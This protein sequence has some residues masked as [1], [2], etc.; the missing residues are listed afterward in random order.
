MKIKDDKFIVKIVCALI[1]IVLWVLA[2]MQVNPPWDYE[3]SNIKVNVKNIAKLEDGN[4]VLMEDV[5]NFI[6][7]VKLSGL[8]NNLLK[9]KSSDI[10]A[11]IDLNKIV[12]KDK[13]GE[14]R[15]PVEITSLDNFE[16]LSFS[17]M[18][19]TCT[20]EKEISKAIDVTVK[21]T[22]VVNDNYYVGRG[23]SKPASIIIRGAESRVESVSEALA[24]VNVNGLEK[25]ITKSI[26]LML[27][28]ANNEDVNGVVMDKS[29]VSI[30]QPIYE[31][32]T[33]SVKPDFIGEPKEGYKLMD[34]ISE[35]TTV[36]IAGRRNILD[37]ISNIITEPLD[38]R[39]QIV[40]VVNDKSLILEDGILVVDNIDK[41]K[42]VAKID[43]IITKE[44]KFNYEDI[45]F[46][47]LDGKYIAKIIDE[48][49]LETE[50]SQVEGSTGIS[51]NNNDNNSSDDDKNSN[52]DDDDK[53]DYDFKVIIKDGISKIRDLDK[54]DIKLYIDCKD[55]TEGVNV[56][57]V[58]LNVNEQFEETSV[59]PDKISVKVELK[60]ENNDKDESDE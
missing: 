4:Y 40:N 23:I 13:S 53:K 60:P 17:P 51:Q 50:D 38:I 42:V 25:D 47:N 33:V 16:V 18:Y 3:F 44:F 52:N 35:R 15:I 6:V 9:I 56:I 32:K 34:V 46:E 10:V 30:T 14:H 58:M 5:N 29:V 21:H 57:I 8:K 45:E 49:Q 24:V 22:G 28:D 11:T 26:S 36:K 48:K 55:V 59:S 27:K 1:A 37:N 2:I 43:R 12:G 19:I 41:V 54:S 39:N 31:T 7:K 20:V